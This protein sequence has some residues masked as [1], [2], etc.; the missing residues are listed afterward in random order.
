MVLLLRWMFHK[1][2]VLK[3]LG[4]AMARLSF[5]TL[6]KVSTSFLV[7]MLIVFSFCFFMTILFCFIYFLYFIY[8]PMLLWPRMSGLSWQGGKGKISWLYFLLYILYLLPYAYLRLTIVLLLR[9]MFHNSA[10]LKVLGFARVSGVTVVNSFISSLLI[11]LKVVVC[12]FMTLIFYCFNSWLLFLSPLPLFLFLLLVSL[13]FPF[14]NTKI[15][16]YL[17]LCNTKYQVFFSSRCAYRP[18]PLLKCLTINGLDKLQTRKNIF[19]I[20]KI[21]NGYG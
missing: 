12:F 13:Y 5:T 17:V 1:S 9:W 20:G 8:F 15:G 14:D 18:I 2:A 11:G 3:V 19:C 7:K 16:L 6:V 21:G 4:L 10:L